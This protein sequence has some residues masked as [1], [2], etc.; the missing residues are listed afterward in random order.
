[1]DVITERSKDWVLLL[2]DAL[3]ESLLFWHDILYKKVSPHQ[4]V[5]TLLVSETLV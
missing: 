3:I 4:L 2:N 5:L 1:M